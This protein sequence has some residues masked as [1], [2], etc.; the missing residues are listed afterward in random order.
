MYN[1]APLNFNGF[2]ETSLLIRP[3]KACTGETTVQVS[4]RNMDG[5]AGVGD[6]NSITRFTLNFNLAGTLQIAS[7]H[8]HTVTLC[9]DGSIKSFGNNNAN[10]L[11]V[12]YVLEEVI[13]T[14][15]F[16]PQ[17]HIQKIY[18]GGRHSAALLQSK[19]ISKISP[20]FFFSYAYK[21]LFKKK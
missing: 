17:G 6:K 10:Q 12:S 19:Y 16:L 20:T 5:E 21:I 13:P 2:S 14:T 7:G 11:G 1:I 4:G 18:A 3:N 15:A 9:E 8:G